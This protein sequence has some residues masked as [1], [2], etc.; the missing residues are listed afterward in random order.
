MGELYSAQVKAAKG[1]HLKYGFQFKEEENTI[2]L[3]QIFKKFSDIRVR[4]STKYGGICKSEFG[5]NLSYTVGDDPSNVK[6]N[7]NKFFSQ[8]GIS[9]EQL[10]VPLQCHSNAVLKVDAP[11]EYRAC[12]CV[13]ILLFDPV[14]KVIG[15]VHA[16]W[17]GTANEIARQAIEKLKEEYRTDPS[18]LIAFIGPSAGSC[19]Y[20]V[21]EDVAVKFRNKVVSFNKAKKYINLKDENKLQL[22][23]E[24]VLLNHIEVSTSCTICDKES[25]HSFRRDGPKSGRMI[26]VICIVL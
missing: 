13:P 9:E 16:G 22:Q 17:R 6:K 7:R 14:N 20:E 26:A 5:M 25:F 24:G 12:D 1:Q 18:K 2:I 19:C 11:G 23:S 8:F 4:M 3:P 15:A 10:A 21:G